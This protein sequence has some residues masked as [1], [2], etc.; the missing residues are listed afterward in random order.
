VI[1]VAS[2]GV[3]ALDEETGHRLG[4]VPGLAPARLLAG[5]DLALQAVDAEGL[6]TGVRLDTHLS[7]IG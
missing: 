3:Q 6:V 2:E 4:H 7:V 1:L 5:A